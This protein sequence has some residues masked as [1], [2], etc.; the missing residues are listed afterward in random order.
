MRPVLCARAGVKL[1]ACAETVCDRIGVLNLAIARRVSSC[2][3]C[4]RPLCRCE[5]AV[6]CVFT[7]N[8]ASAWALSIVQDSWE[9][10]YPRGSHITRRLSEMK[11]CRGLHTGPCRKVVASTILA[12]SY[13]PCM[14]YIMVDSSSNSGVPQTGVRYEKGQDAITTSPR[15]L[16]VLRE[17]QPS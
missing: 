10:T 16:V 9:S 17:P 3:H 7:R 11:E 1:R 12:L 4:C 13:L 2:V 8:R 5:C 14:K 6:T 15:T